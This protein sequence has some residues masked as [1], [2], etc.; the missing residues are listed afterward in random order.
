VISPRLAVVAG[1]TETLSDMPSLRALA[2]AGLSSGKP[3][4]RPDTA[5][6]ESMG[7][8][9]TSF[10]VL[11]FPWAQP[12]GARAGAVVVTAKW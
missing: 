3:T 7:T 10:T 5:V 12:S 6:A 2:V 4:N 9:P 11:A 8:S 1:R